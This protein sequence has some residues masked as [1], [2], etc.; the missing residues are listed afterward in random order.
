METERKKIKALEETPKVKARI[1]EY[2]RTSLRK[3]KDQQSG[4]QKKIREGKAKN[5]M[6]IDHPTRLKNIED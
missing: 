3:Y 1:E 6:P 5:T 4:V 2:E